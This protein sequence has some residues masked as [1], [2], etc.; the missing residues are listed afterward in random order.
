M[1]S[2]SSLKDQPDSFG[3]VSIA[4][5]WLTALV[6]CVLWYL[7]KSIGFQPLEEMADRRSLHVTLGLLAW[8]LLA[9][10]I[11]W[12]LRNGHPR[13]QGQTEL[14]HRAARLAHYLM[15]ALLG[16]MLISGPLLA[17]TLSSRTGLAGIAHPIHELTANLLLLLVAVHI[18]GALK[19]LM[20]NDDETLARIFV[21]K[22][23]AML[24]KSENGE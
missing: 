19:H 16:I 15:L 9:G 23:R 13:A 20:F 24:D 6:I 21:P 14:I 22:R 11:A 7:G 2:V 12:R 5:H 8:L 17:L 3:W 18:G 1:N 10:R 4:L